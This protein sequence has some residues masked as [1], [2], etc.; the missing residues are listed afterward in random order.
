VVTVRPVPPPVVRSTSG[1]AFTLW[2]SL[3]LSPSSVSASAVTLA[4]VESLLCL[5]FNASLSSLSSPLTGLVLYDR[6]LSSSWF[7]TLSLSELSLE[8][9]LR[10]ATLRRQQEEG[11]EQSSPSPA[12]GEDPEGAVP[13]EVELE[14]EVERGGRIFAVPSPLR[15]T[16]RRGRGVGRC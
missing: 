16:L 10:S 1:R 6:A 14:A 5:L 4:D 15:V 11:E 12:A 9:C 7:P 8:K 13:E 3:S 2:D